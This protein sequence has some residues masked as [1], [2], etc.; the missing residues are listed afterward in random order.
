MR[1]WK[2]PLEQ[3]PL[4]SYKEKEGETSFEQ[5]SGSEIGHAAESGVKVV[6]TNQSGAEPGAHQQARHLV[7]FCVWKEQGRMA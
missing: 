7:R 2:A 3:D 6:L 5:E 4:V 1:W